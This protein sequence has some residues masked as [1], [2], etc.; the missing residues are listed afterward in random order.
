MGIPAS[1]CDTWRNQ[2]ATASAKAAHEAVRSALS[3]NTS[4][5]RERDFEVFLQGSYKNDTNIRADSD[6]DVV[7]QL[8]ETFY[9]DTSELQEP[10]KT[11]CEQAFGS[12]SYSLDTFDAD[13]QKSLRGYFG[14]S[15]VTVNNRCLTVST[16]TG[17]LTAD[18]VVASQYR[19]YRHFP[20]LTRQDF[21]EG[22]TFWG[23][24]DNLQV[25][26]YPKHHYDNGIDKNADS[27]GNYKSSV[28]MLKNARRY[29]V[30]RGTLDASVAPSYFVECWLFNIPNDRF[31]AESD[32]TFYN[33]LKWLEN[34]PDWTKFVTQSWQQWLFGSA[35]VQWSTDRA[36]QLH[37]RLVTLWNE[38]D[39]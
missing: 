10:E 15:S 22:I 11:R 19:R 3:A 28:R 23:R 24:H 33:V 5:V 34:N 9:K 27:A 1:Q 26:N 8:N 25:I 20:D 4:V 2:G 16:G 38:W 32:E 30:E 17:R 36:K 29:L 39:S 14:S 37:Q 18:V 31:V 21:A 6:V 13:V 7:V 12:A 35:S